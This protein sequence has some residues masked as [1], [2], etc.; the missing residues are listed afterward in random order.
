MPT[1]LEELM[2]HFGAVVTHRPQH[3]IEASVL[4]H[5]P[6]NV[7]TVPHHIDRGWVDVP[8]K[9]SAFSGYSHSSRLPYRRT[10]STQRLLR[11][12]PHS[13][14]VHDCTLKRVFRC[15]PPGT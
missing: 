14:R 3:V 13:R 2:N 6:E 4:E 15:C 1:L 10:K 7:T 5:A 12:C 9:P 8:E 11:S